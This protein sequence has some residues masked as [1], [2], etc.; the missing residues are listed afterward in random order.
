M[1]RYRGFEE[2]QTLHV[3]RL[4]LIYGENNTGKS[5]LVRLLPLL[6]DSCDPRSPGPISSRSKAMR[7]RSFLSLFWREERQG[8]SIEL[9]WDDLSVRY[10]FAVR[11]DGAA[12]LGVIERC[13]VLASG[14]VIA[15]A[16]ARAG[17]PARGAPSHVW[18]VGEGDTFG[19]T[20]QG[21]L[22]RVEPAGVPPEALR[23]ISRRVELLYG[24]VQ[25]LHARRAMLPATDTALGDPL[26]QLE[27]DGGDVIRVLSSQPNAAQRVADWFGKHEKLLFE[28]S[29]AT[30]AKVASL[31]LRDPKARGWGM[32]MVDGS[33]GLQFVVPVLTATGLLAL[34]KENAPRVLALEEPEGH[35]HGRLQRA[36]AEEII[37][38]LETTPDARVVIET[39]SPIFLTAVQLAVVR[40][41]KRRGDGRLPLTSRDVALT[42]AERADGASTLRTIELDDAAVPVTN[43]LAEFF[44]QEYAIARDLQRA[45]NEA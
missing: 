4:T 25:W 45:R 16:A 9:I 11:D 23:E 44:S 15:T 42:L 20:F 30:E 43:D 18:R 13:E 12:Q 10:E 34:Q 31:K 33:E 21:L 32:N 26:W 38:M 40:G 6:A 19:G 1:R 22:P 36:L 41:V 28:V 2:E 24:S 27:P 7:D 5:A 3:R 39:H 8:L 35:L 17:F 14:A 29:R 37:D